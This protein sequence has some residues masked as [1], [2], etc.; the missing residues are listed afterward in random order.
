MK[1]LI[2]G[3]TGYIGHRLALALAAKKIQV[4]A[5]VRDVNSIKIPK[6]PNIKV[7]QGDICDLNSIKRAITGCQY[8]FHT[9]AYTNLKNRNIDDFYNIN[10]LGTE[11]ILNAALAEGIKKVIYTSTLSVFGPS[12][13]QKPIT[14][15][16][17]RLVSYAN[18]Y[19]LTKAMAE[20]KVRAYTRNGLPCVILNLTRVYGPGLKSFSNGVNKLVDMITYKSWLVVPSKLETMANYVYIDDVLNAH[21]SAMTLGKN[22]ERYIIGGENLNYKQL[23]NKIKKYTKSDIKI[24][25]LNYNILKIILILISKINA[26]LKIGTSLSPRVIDSIFTN[27]RS[28][29]NK[30]ISELQYHI[31]PFKKGIS[32]T[33]AYLKN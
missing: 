26:I 5:L 21:I 18:D 23:F 31:T 2:T 15:T 33:I 22:G 28:S 17:P 24:V 7:F 16:Q 14:E 27:R 4:N 19:E 1:V 29:S 8:V 6:H 25:Q 3:A 10:V 11:H 20:E 12:F 13:K 30:A 32:K 9:A